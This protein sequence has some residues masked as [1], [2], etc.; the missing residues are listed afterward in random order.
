MSD[1]RAPA[2]LPEVGAGRPAPA[3]LPRQ[4]RGI[5]PQLHGRFPDYDVL[6]QAGHWDEVTRRVVLDRVE[7]VPEIVFFEPAELE[8]VTAFADLVTP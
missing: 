7:N 3:G 5:T 8:T 6:E 2:H 1:F 4:R